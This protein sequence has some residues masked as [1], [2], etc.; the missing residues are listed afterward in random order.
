[1]NKATKE[2]TSILR[3][4]GCAPTV[5][6]DTNGNNIIKVNAPAAPENNI[7]REGLKK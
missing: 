4:C 7:K 6:T 2:I 3:A 1:M 5:A